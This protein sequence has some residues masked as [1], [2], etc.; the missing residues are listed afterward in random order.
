MLRGLP[1]S[2]WVLW[3]STVI[4]VAGGLGYPMMSL[5]VG[6]HLGYSVAF[7][8]LVVTAIGLGA[9]LAS[10]PVGALSDRYGRRWV[11]FGG[12]TMAAAGMCVLALWPSQPGL[13]IGAFLYGF[14]GWG[15]R[16]VRMA[17]VADLVPPADRVRAYNLEYWAVN[18]GFAVSAALGG[19]LAEY[20]FSLVFLINAATLLT[21]ALWVC[22]E[23]PE[24]RPEPEESTVEASALTVLAD[25]AFLA[26]VLLAAVIELVQLTAFVVLPLAVTE[27]GLTPHDYGLVLSLNGVTIVL[28]QPVL[29]RL[30]EHRAPQ[31]VLAL[32]ALLM[33]VGMSGNLLATGLLGFCLAGFVWT[34]GEILLASMTGA[35]IAGLAP[36]H[37]RGRYQ[38]V[39]W[40][41]PTAATLLAPLLSGVLTQ[42]AGTDAVWW[43]CLLDGVLVAAGLLAMGARL[44]PRRLELSAAETR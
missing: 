28:V 20:S 42:R 29:S 21:A 33:G 3:S 31:R 26:F 27:Q 14:G 35:V 32:G 6:D 1:R 39:F 44:R 38:G 9:L 22:F 23:V 10:A 37:L 25:R 11:L 30:V 17:M 40:M 7:A 34:I 4:L 2:F 36:P 5:Y 13:L 18:I 8:G 12:Q 15:V 19:F 24:T 41:A 16:P 43:A